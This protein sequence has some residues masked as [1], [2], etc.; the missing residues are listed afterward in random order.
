MK[1]PKGAPQMCPE[2]PAKGSAPQKGLKEP[3]KTPP[4][5]DKASP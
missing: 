5:K 2:G 1:G 4:K 3:P